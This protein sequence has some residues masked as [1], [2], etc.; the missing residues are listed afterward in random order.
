MVS[1]LIM[2]I[3]VEQVLTVCQAP[4]SPGGS[5]PP[6]GP[7]PFYCSAPAVSRAFCVVP[8]RHGADKPQNYQVWQRA[9]DRVRIICVEQ[10]GSFH[11][12]PGL[13]CFSVACGSSGS[14][15]FVVSWFLCTFCRLYPGP[16]AGTGVLEGCVPSCLLAVSQIPSSS[17]ELTAEVLLG[18]D[19][20]SGASSLRWK[21]RSVWPGDRGPESRQQSKG[22]LCG[23]AVRGQS[24]GLTSGTHAGPMSPGT[25]PNFYSAFCFFSSNVGLKMSYNLA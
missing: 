1:F 22:R 3:N 7:A 16:S 9:E 23:P 2:M 17:V 8:V 19:G 11:P 21:Q 24:E 18:D 6:E 25:S 10:G 12:V 5:P 13:E 4:V 14:C 20:H 15:V